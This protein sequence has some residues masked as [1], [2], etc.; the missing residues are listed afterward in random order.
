MSTFTN[1]SFFLCT[2]GQVELSSCLLVCNHNVGDLCDPGLLSP[3][4]R[5]PL[6]LIVSLLLDKAVRGSLSPREGRSDSKDVG[7]NFSKPVESSDTCLF[8]LPIPGTSATLG[9]VGREKSAREVGK[10]HSPHGTVLFVAVSF[11]FR[12]EVKS[13]LIHGKENQSQST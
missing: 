12:C 5:F 7:K 6:V 13:E 4:L 8:L 9:K 1:Q 3:F 10:A 2:L 11:R